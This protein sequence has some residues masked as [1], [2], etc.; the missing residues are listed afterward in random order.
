MP[1]PVPRG[2]TYG[3]GAA[4]PRA[5]NVCTTTTGRIWSR[6]RHYRPAPTIPSRRSDC[7]TPHPE[8]PH[9]TTSNLAELVAFTRALQ[10]AAR[11]PLAT[12][13]PICIRYNSEYAAR[14]AT[15]AWKA[16]K[17]KAMAAEA[18]QSWAKLQSL[19]NGRTWMRH[20]STKD[21]SYSA[22]CALAHSGKRG[23]HTYSL[24]TH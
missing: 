9:H 13:R 5:K 18:R 11:H 17:H 19:N 4:D 6:G 3:P 16:K 2:D 21:D 15:G 24:V 10:W 12:G 20:T 8:R 14:I 7:G 22:A 1:Q 23:A